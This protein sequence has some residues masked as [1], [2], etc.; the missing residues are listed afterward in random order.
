M[1]CGGVL[2]CLVVVVGFSGSCV[3][4]FDR[5]WQFEASHLLERRRSRSSRSRCKVSG[6]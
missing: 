2:W 6:L 5:V 4:V 3:F 1:A